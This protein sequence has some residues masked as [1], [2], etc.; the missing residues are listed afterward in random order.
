MKHPFVLRA[1]FFESNAAFTKSHVDVHF[2]WRTSLKG[3]ESRSELEWVQRTTG[4][5]LDQK[6]FKEIGYNGV[7]PIQFPENMRS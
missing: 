4:Q 6:S 7:F 1:F 3:V 5:R 2:H